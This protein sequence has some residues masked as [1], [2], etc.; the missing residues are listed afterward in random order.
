MRTCWVSVLCVESNSMVFVAAQWWC[1]S[2]IPIIGPGDAIRAPVV[3]W[4]LSPKLVASWP[5]T[6]SPAA[7]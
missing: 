4:L 1:A 7:V 3:G 5:P 2:A 6:T